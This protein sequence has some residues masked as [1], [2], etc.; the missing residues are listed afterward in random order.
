MEQ[1]EARKAMEE[2]PLWLSVLRTQYS[3]CEDM[4]SIPGLAQ[5]VKDP[6][7]LQAAAQVAKA[8][9]IWYCYVSGVGQQLSSDLNPSP[10]TFIRHW[11]GC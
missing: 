7:L 4:G 6:V 2:F 3:I 5:W 9:Q 8:T 11:W 1:N 10:G